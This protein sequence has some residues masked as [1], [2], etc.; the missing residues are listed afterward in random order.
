MRGGGV[1]AVGEGSVVHSVA[2]SVNQFQSFQCLFSFCMQPCLAVGK[3]VLEYLFCSRSVE[4]RVFHTD[5][6]QRSAH[7]NFAQY[8]L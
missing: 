1:T 7:F 8:E 3:S 5:Q 2:T 4:W 6:E